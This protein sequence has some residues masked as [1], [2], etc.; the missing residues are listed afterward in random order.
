[1]L[2]IPWENISKWIVDHLNFLDTYPITSR[3]IR[4]IRLAFLNLKQVV[5]SL[6]LD[7]AKDSIFLVK[8]WCGLESN[9]KLRGVRIRDVQISH[10]EQTSSLRLEQRIK[11]VLK[12]GAFLVVRWLGV[13]ALAIVTSSCRI[14][15]LH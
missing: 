6:T 9:A 2:Q 12:E 5:Y 1:L 11:L 3:S 10:E 13:D 14:S 8:L 7:P 4:R 15:S